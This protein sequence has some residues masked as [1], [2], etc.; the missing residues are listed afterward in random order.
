MKFLFALLILLSFKSHADSSAECT[1]VKGV[2]EN[3]KELIHDIRFETLAD[4]FSISNANAFKFSLEGDN[5][6]FLRTDIEVK[7]Q[8]KAIFMMKKTGRPFRV[9]HM[10]IDRSPQKISKDKEFYGNMI[11]SQ[12]LTDGD[13]TKFDNSKSLR[14][15]FYCSF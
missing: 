5:L 4:V 13:W 2:Y 10:M 14:Y 8:I 12:K 3:S 7:K 15:N 6:K 9:I 1:L 11:V